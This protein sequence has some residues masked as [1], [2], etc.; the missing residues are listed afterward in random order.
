[1]STVIRPADKP[2]VRTSARPS[3]ETE[4]LAANLV[5]EGAADQADLGIELSRITAL[6]PSRHEGA[7]ALMT[8]LGFPYF[9]IASTWAWVRAYGEPW[10]CQTANMRR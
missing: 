6:P 10:L 3:A 7:E 2:L 5:L 1:M 9:R 8:G 4:S